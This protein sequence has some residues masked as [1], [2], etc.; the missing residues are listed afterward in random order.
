MKGDGLRR[1]LPKQHWLEQSSK[2]AW[3][4]LTDL[5]HAHAQYTTDPQPP[6]SHLTLH[7]IAGNRQIL[8]GNDM[9]ANVHYMRNSQFFFSPQSH[10][11]HAAYGTAK[12]ARLP[13]K[14][15]QEVWYRLPESAKPRFLIVSCMWSVAW[16]PDGLMGVN[17]GRESG[18]SNE[19]LPPGLQM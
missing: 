14:S 7:R 3:R 16:Q 6:Y 11:T 5:S 9:A 12:K 13:R 10:F 4:Y 19:A 2:I 17:F 15:L 8:E 1:G 18:A